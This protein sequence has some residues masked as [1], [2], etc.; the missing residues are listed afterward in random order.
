MPTT[1]VGDAAFEILV[2]TDEDN[3]VPRFQLCVD[4]IAPRK[5]YSVYDR[6]RRVSYDDIS[7][8]NLLATLVRKN[9]SVIEAEVGN[10]IM[11]AIEALRGTSVQVVEW[12]KPEL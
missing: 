2:A 4:L 3:W 11:P 6:R 10:I 9:I 1:D 8:H 7:I 5:T 12:K